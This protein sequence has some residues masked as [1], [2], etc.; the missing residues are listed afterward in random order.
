MPP[1]MGDMARPRIRIHCQEILCYV[2]S[3]L[4]ILVFLISEYL[5]PA[6]KEKDAVNNAA[7]DFRKN[8]EMGAG[9][10]K[11]CSWINVLG[12]PLVL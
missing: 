3:A 2:P 9:G 7:E 6:R 11:I 4:N 1:V 8:A 12:F 5:Y 10:A